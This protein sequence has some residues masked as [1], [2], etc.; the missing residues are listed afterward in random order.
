MN[1]YSENCDKVDKE[2]SSLIQ[3]L[4]DDEFWNYIRTWFSTEYL[5]DIMNDWPTELKEEAIEKILK[6]RHKKQ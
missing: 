6:I 5:L 1:Y 4:S 2:L 3:D